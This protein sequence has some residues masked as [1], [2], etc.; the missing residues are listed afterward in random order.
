MRTDRRYKDAENAPE[1]VSEKRLTFF[2]PQEVFLSVKRK[3]SLCVIA[4]CDD[5]ADK[6]PES[7]SSM[8][9]FAIEVL[10][11]QISGLNK[12]DEAAL[13]AKIEAMKKAVK[14]K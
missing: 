9:R 3:A 4:N 14:K 6:L 1:I 8:V 12:A 13:L 5:G 7:P 2:L 10:D 11:W